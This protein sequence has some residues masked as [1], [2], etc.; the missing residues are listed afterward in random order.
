MIFAYRNHDTCTHDNLEFLF[1][2][3]HLQDEMK[4]SESELSRLKA[5]KTVP[6]NK[7]GN[8]MSGL[9]SLIN[10]NESRF[11][12]RPVG[13]IGLHVKL[14]P[15][16]EK[17][18][19]LI[20]M[21][22]SRGKTLCG[23]LV[24]RISDIKLLQSLMQKCGLRSDD[25]PVFNRNDRTQPRYRFS[26]NEVPSREIITMLDVLEIDD[27]NVFR[28]LVDVHYINTTMMAETYEN[29]ERMF[30]KRNGANALPRNVT[31]A[32]TRDKFQR[33]NIKHGSEAITSNQKLT[34]RYLTVGQENVEDRINDL[35]RSIHEF[36]WVFSV[37]TADYPCSF[38]LHRCL[39]F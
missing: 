26:D 10:E 21:N 32:F 31:T 28:H 37:L 30:E 11:A 27:D 39:M 25:H 7:Y 19:G 12:S 34:A 8:N 9:I 4:T 17:W 2:Q 36:R 23:F 3:K 33:I 6:I 29:V 22:L 14:K 16:C 5:S 35:E 38:S 24:F 15:G 1:S 18:A 13:P 20:E